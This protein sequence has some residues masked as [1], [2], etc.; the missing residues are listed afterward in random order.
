MLEF[1][2]IKELF[3]KVVPVFVVIVVDY[4]ISRNY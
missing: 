4:I 3:T 1:T 2:L